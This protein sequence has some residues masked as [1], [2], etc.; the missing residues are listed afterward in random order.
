M[1]APTEKIIA[2]AA[3]EGVPVAAIARIVGEPLDEIYQT[4][5]DQKAQGLII[6][7]PRADWPPGTRVVDRV[8]STSLPDDADLAFMCKTTFR[9]TGLEASFLVTL[10]KHRHVEKNRL[11]HIVEQQRMTRASQPDAR[12][13]T[14]PKMVDVMI[15]KLRK[16][17]KVVDPELKIETIW[18]GGYYIEP[19]M[20]PR[21][22][23]HVN[24]EPDAPPESTA[25]ITNGDPV[26]TIH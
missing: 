2:N 26:A 25:S 1:S 10:L 15:C 3:N 17:L 13:A 7:L 4:L 14:D 19:A 11:H 12:E 16:K 9:L 23:A 8:P 22:I 20:K 24:G 18:G 5:K 21:I 6:S